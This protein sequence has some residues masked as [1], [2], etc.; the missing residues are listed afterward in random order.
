LVRQAEG[1]A[2][3]VALG[4]LEELLGRGFIQPDEVEGDFSFTHHLMQE[5][6]YA[7]LT[8]PRRAYLQRRLAEAIQALHPN[9]FEALAYHFAQAGDAERARLYYLQAGDHAWRLLALSDAAGYYQAALERWPDKDLAGRAEILYKLGQCQW[10]IMELQKALDSFEV[11]RDLF[12]VCGEQVRAG[13]MERMIGRMQW[14]LG[15]GG[16]AWLHYRQALAMLEEGPETVELART[17]SSISQMYMLASQ[18][19]EAIAWGERALSLA[20]RFGAEDVIVHVLNNV[21]TAR[22]TVYDYNPEQGVFML[23][24]SV[25]RAKLLG[26]PHDVCRDYVNLVVILF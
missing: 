3:E 19:E 2:D 17:L 26:L 15:D 24:E 6:I 22:M 4:A 5:A 9:N 18:Y 8:G 1:W 21:G 11:A 20:E 13:D 7:D 10:V 25:Q 16:A 12:Q 14:E 23:R